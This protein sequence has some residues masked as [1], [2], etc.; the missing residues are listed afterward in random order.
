MGHGRRMLVT[1]LL[2]SAAGGSEGPTVPCCR[3]F[4][5]ALEATSAPRS[6]YLDIEF[7]A[8]FTHTQS[9]RTFEVEGFWDGGDVFRLRFAPMV[10][11][12]WTYAT[13]SNDPGLDGR[14]G[15]FQ[16]VPSG[17]RGHIQVDPAHP[18]H[19]SYGDGTPFYWAGVTLTP[20]G[21]DYSD[22]DDTGMG[23]ERYKAIVDTR[24]EQ[25]FT[26][27]YGMGDLFE[28]PGFSKRTQRNEGGPP[29][30]DY[31]PARLNPAFFQGVDRRVKHVMSSGLVQCIGLG[32][33]DQGIWE[34]IGEDALER[35]WR[36][37]IARYAAYDVCWVIFGE[38]EEFGLNADAIADQFGRLTRR[39]D[40]YQHP[41]SVHSTS[42]SARLAKHEWLDFTIQQSR[43]W[44][45]VS[46]DRAAGKPVVNAEYY[47]ENR[48][49]ERHAQWPHIITNPHLIRTGAWEI[50]SRGGYFVY[51]I[52]GAT[53]D[54]PHHLR[55]EAA[56][57]VMHA[58]DLMRRLPYSRL[59]PR[60]NLSD[61]GVCLSDGRRYLLCYLPCGGEAAVDLRHFT[62]P[63][64][65][66]WFDTRAGAFYRAGP[67]A[68]Q[69]SRVEAPDVR[70]WVLLADPQ[71]AGWRDE[72][73]P[74]PPAYDAPDVSVLREG[75]PLID[76][77]FELNDGV[78]ANHGTLGSPLHLA[79]D[80]PGHLRRLEG[81]G[82]EV[83]EPVTLKT[84][85]DAAALV[86]RL[87][88]ANRFLI[89]LDIEAAKV[90]QDGP[91]RIVTLSKDPGVRD[92]TVGQAGARLAF[93][94]RTSTS[95][96]N[97]LPEWIPETPLFGAGR[98]RF[99][100]LFDGT[101]GYV[102]KDERLLAIQQDV[103]RD[104]GDWASYPLCVANE[105]DGARPWLGKLWRLRV[106]APP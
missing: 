37:L 73:L 20:F 63:M 97:G 61:A 12:G 67:C 43:D 15:S 22:D 66:R 99:A 98:V 35:A 25:G 18:C 2:A 8:T 24:A 71:P 44:P 5:E 64:R 29:F 58:N 101:N 85:Q 57:Y 23:F 81:G 93:R 36:Y 51:E 28:K 79:P 19:F 11:G 96:D 13:T 60:P 75:R 103:S 87:V 9:G 70:D 100:I 27:L 7:A 84:N 65:M 32:W 68:P 74:F 94:L 77:D 105:A 30:H 10:A 86:A 33:P 17:S 47:Y 106:W 54:W 31:D 82:L 50:L 59:E 1:L 34:R 6:P 55:T 56:A 52:W 3:V 46:G 95:T 38:Y 42:S 41:I 90:E 14:T 39:R 4:E 104:L 49:G 26:V 62:G 53:R 92:F 72:S 16:C 89:E 69:A 102:F 78:I 21:R 88:Q 83:V 91:A 76:Y 45:L 40:A 48:T 80:E